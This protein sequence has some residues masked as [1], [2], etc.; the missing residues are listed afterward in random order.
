MRANRLRSRSI[1]DCEVDP[2]EI[3]E[4]SEDEWGGV[5]PPEVEVQVLE[6]ERVVGV[7]LLNTIKITI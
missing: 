4:L 6:L 3:E 5:L 1:L 2:P 7:G